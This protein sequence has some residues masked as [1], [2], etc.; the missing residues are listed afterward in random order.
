MA[1]PIPLDAPVTSATFRSTDA[2]FLRSRADGGP[3]VPTTDRE[4]QATATGPRRRSSSGALE[5]A[6]FASFSR[7]IVVFDFLAPLRR[8]ITLGDHGSERRFGNRSDHSWG[9]VL[10]TAT[11][12]RRQWLCKEQSSNSLIFFEVPKL[13]AIGSC[14]LQVGFGAEISFCSREC[15][16]QISLP[17]PSRLDRLAWLLLI[18]LP[19]SA[20]GGHLRSAC[21]RLTGTHQ[22][23]SRSDACFAVK[24]AGEV[25][26]DLVFRKVDR[27]NCHWAARTA[28]R[29]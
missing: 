8:A 9:A 15:R 18:Y 27:G 16:I 19:P 29:G 20:Q 1:R 2:Q 5:F 23:R 26:E 6:A 3:V 11:G 12:G 28:A 24:N 13:A 22:S 25:R 10:A 4:F 14:R 17:E 21:A 7:F